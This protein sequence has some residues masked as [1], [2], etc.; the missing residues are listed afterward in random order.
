MS[1]S[2][3]GG[4]AVEARGGCTG[5]EVYGWGGRWWLMWEMVLASLFAGVNYVYFAIKRVQKD[6]TGIVVMSGVIR[7]KM[8]LNRPFSLCSNT[9]KCRRN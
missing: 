8:V 2:G 3:V 9:F 4:G 1:G 7:G 5:D 6:V